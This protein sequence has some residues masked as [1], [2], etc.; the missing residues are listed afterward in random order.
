MLPKTVLLV[1]G[2]GDDD[3]SAQAKVCDAQA[4]LDKDVNQLKNLDLADTSVNDVKDQLSS[5]GDD[6]E[7]LKDAGSE[8]L[9]PQIDAIKSAAD[10]LGT[11]VGNLGSSS[12]LSETASSLQTSLS[13]LGTATSDL[14]TAA[15]ETDNC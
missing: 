10:D 4:Q 13:Q 11:M 5:I 2:C 15:Q 12:S 14:K 9:Q 7:D 1:A 8:K 6:V 3:D